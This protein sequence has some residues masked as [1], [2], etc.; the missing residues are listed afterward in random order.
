MTNV[1]MFNLP[2]KMD[3]GLMFSHFGPGN[4]MQEMLDTF[5]IP[6]FY[7]TKIGKTEAAGGGCVRVFLCI[8]RDGALIAQLTVV[9]PA[10]SM[11]AAARIAEHAAFDA[12][13]CCRV[14]SEAAH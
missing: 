2:A 14:A 3:R 13:N 9:M 5:G 6:E 8:E 4:I 11:L 10:L 7:V 12:F 1:R